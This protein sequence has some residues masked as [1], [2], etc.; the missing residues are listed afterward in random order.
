MRPLH[1]TGGCH[2]DGEDRG[3]RRAVVVL[4]RIV[5]RCRD[6]VVSVRVC[7]DRLSVGVQV[8]IGGIGEDWRGRGR[9]LTGA[10]V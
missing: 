3:H 4:V 7:V 10:L 2:G 9:E 6:G 5:V 1:G 8:R